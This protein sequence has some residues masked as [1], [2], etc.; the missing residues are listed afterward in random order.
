MVPQVGRY[1]LYYNIITEIQQHK[2]NIYIICTVLLYT[3]YRHDET[4]RSIIISPTSRREACCDHSVQR[5]AAA[6]QYSILYACNKYDWGVGTM[7]RDVNYSGDV[8]LTMTAV[9]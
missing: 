6:G 8:Y 2:R 5:K 7:H 4:H 9:L 3:V 1:Y